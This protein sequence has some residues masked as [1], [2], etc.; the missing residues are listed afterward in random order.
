MNIFLLVIVDLLSTLVGM[1]LH[2]Y[3]FCSGSIALYCILL[4]IQQFPFNGSSIKSIVDSIFAE[5]QKKEMLCTFSFLSLPPGTSTTNLIQ[6]TI[7]FSPLLPMTPVDHGLFIRVLGSFIVISTTQHQLEAASLIA[8]DGNINPSPLP[9]CTCPPSQVDQA[10][11]H[12]GPR[13]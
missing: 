13:T 5:K 12:D 10:E 8:D 3:R 6:T 11:R 4:H 1:F 9:T 7:D 2:L